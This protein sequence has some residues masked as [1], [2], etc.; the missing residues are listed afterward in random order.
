[1]KVKSSRVA[2]WLLL[3]MSLRMA[4]NAQTRATRGSR[5]RMG[6]EAAIVITVVFVVA[7][8]LTAAL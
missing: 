8:L 2:T 6:Y 1:M 3:A 7:L 4:Q 5:K